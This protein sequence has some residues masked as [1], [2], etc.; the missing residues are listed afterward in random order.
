MVLALKELSIRGDISTTVDYISKLIEF[1]DFVNNN[2]DTALLE[3]LIKGNVVGIGS[4]KGLTRS[5]SSA[6]VSILADDTYAMMGELIVAFDDS[7]RGEEQFI[8]ALAKG[9]LRSQSLLQMEKELS[10]SS[11]NTN[12]N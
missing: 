1:D 5:I 8:D 11:M 4:T 3:R 7:T 2:I 10:S 9:Q 6:K 12:T